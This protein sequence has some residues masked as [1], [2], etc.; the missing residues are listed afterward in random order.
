[1]EGALAAEAWVELWR[2]V[3]R[4]WTI[5]FIVTGSAYPVMEELAQAYEK[6]IG[7][8]GAEALAIT[9]G[10]A[11][12]LQRLERDLHALTETARGSSVA[13]AIA[14][15]ER[16][17]PNLASLAGGVDFVRALEAFLALHGDIGQE[18]FDLESAP[19]RDEPARLLAV[20]AQRLRSEGEHPDTRVAR[21]RERA[22]ETLDRARGHLAERPEDLAR[23]EEILAAAMGAG[24]LTEEHNY[25]IDRL[26][27]AHV[28]RF[29][30]AVGARFVRDAVLASADEIFLLYVP[31][32][33]AALR[34]PKPLGDLV[35]RRRNELA[36]WRRLTCP[37]TIGAASSAP[38]IV[39]PGAALER[40]SFDYSVVQDNRYTLKGVAASAG[41]ARGP[42]RII[43][44]DSDFSKMRAGDVL[45]CRQSTVSWAPLYTMASA[46]VTEIGGAL[47]HAAVVARE[48]GVPAVVATGGVLSTVT[49][50]E[51]IE[52]DGNAGTVRRLFPITWTDPEDAKL[53]WRRDDAHQTG[54]RAPLSI[55]YSLKGASYGM[56]KR[57]E[58]LGPPVLTR[59]AAFNGRMYNSSKPL[60]PPDEMVR[61]QM[62]AVGRRRRLARR[63][64]QDWD[65]RYLPELDEIYVWMSALR[66]ESMAREDAVN[67]WDDLWRRHRRAWV[68][69]M[70]VT[71]GSYAVMDEL[72]Q[73]YHDLV[74]GPALDAF[75]LTQGLAPS[76]QRMD[77]ELA[78]LAELAR[79][80][81]A[82][83]G[84]VAR[85]AS[86]DELRSLDPGF[87]HSVDAFLATHGDNGQSS[88]GLGKPAWSDE[89]SL[90]IGTIGTRLGQAGE[91]P[92]ARLA[93]L[94]ENA[95]GIAR[96]AR[97][98]LAGRT[99]ELA[100]F[101]EVLAAARSAGPLTEEHNYWL[102]RRNQAQMGRA[103]RRFGVRLAAEGALPDAE[104][105]LLLYLPEVREALRNPTD[106]SALVA[107]REV[108]QR[109]WTD[110][111]APETLGADAPPWQPGSGVA[112]VGLSYLLFKEVQHDPSRM[113]RGVGAS[114][115]IARG[116]ARLVRNLGEFGK[117]KSGDV[118]VCQAS[119]VSW[120]P[121]FTTAA[122]VVTEVGGALSHAAV[123]AREFGVPAVVGTAVALSTLV[124]G[125]PLEVDGGAGVVR[126]LSA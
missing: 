94:H 6:L 19:W 3:N 35:A 89:P 56:Q 37:A 24:P 16:S 12:T 109:R 80:S 9:Q 64:R 28:R 4:I 86:L 88:E 97:E 60:R 83:A 46:V 48:F 40:V 99:E 78:E 61:H 96:R 45:V 85:G 95:D 92:D 108:E 91:D 53:V 117:F 41:I 102:D 58:K 49:D 27:Q 5:H 47:C 26:S 124:D 20:L 7:G 75:A 122:A 101:E 54:I 50:G 105:I 38:Q 90:L 73:T 33:A 39:A 125:E 121:L 36:R 118:L 52:V 66:P 21:V 84:A 55:E 106:L 114:A 110:M 98:R 87:G 11:P 116:P 57:D 63:I 74:G 22:T 32:I 14:E 103:V 67:E 42:A 76:L 1:M 112:L 79:R 29:V 126:R 119:N 23:F 120:I 31:E 72:G 59:F 104:A 17:V 107:E 51:P 34:A 13:T 69:H 113:L 123:V 93:R 111:E 8:K 2:R 30:H 81:P 65:E 71:A 82:L 70:L 77:K 44:G 62:D 100:R 25:W 115:G 68:I 10:Q 18:N 43:I 15:G